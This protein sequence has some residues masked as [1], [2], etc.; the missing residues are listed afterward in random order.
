[1]RFGLIGSSALQ[2]SQ[3]RHLIKIKRENFREKK[4]KQPMLDSSQVKPTFRSISIKS[5]VYFCPIKLRMHTE[6]VGSMNKRRERERRFV[7]LLLNQ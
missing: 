6:S 5:L 2:F 4:I 3:S 1:M 7:F